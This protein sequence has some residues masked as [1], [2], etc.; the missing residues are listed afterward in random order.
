MTQF[1]FECKTGG[2][3]MVNFRFLSCRGPNNLT[4]CH[5]CFV[6]AFYENYNKIANKGTTSFD[7]CCPWTCAIFLRF[8]AGSV[9]A[10]RKHNLELLLKKQGV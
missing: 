8:F 2:Q 4:G 6:C 3:S 9:E 5:T 1:E 10:F 7:L